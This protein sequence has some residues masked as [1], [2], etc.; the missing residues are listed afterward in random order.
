MKENFINGNVYELKNTEKF[1]AIRE[2]IHEAPVFRKINDRK[3]LENRV[4]NRERIRSTG[5]GHGIAIAHGKTDK[6]G[7]IFLALGIS[8]K[9]IKFNSS[10]DKPVRLLFMIANPPDMQNEY[11]SVLSSLLRIV[12]R[13]NF[14]NRMLSCKTSK[15]IEEIIIKESN[16]SLLNKSF[17]FFH[18]RE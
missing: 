3:D 13:V 12:S 15:E 11:L 14:R 4:I 2:L 8:H 6:I 5:I 18:N 7:S 9:G 10:D 16:N 1:D 17:H